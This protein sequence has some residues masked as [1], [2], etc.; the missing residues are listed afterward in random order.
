MGREEPGDSKPITNEWGW[1]MG[2]P[3]AEVGVV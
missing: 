2:G 1:G 3:W